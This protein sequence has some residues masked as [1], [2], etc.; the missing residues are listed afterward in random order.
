[1]VIGH[2]IAIVG[3]DHAGTLADLGLLHLAGGARPLFGI[4]DYAHNGVSAL[5]IDRNRGAI[6]LGS[7]ARGISL[8]LRGGFGLR[9][10]QRVIRG[11]IGANA[12]P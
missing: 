3:D 11:G 12:G 8:G 6:V 2:D 4:G 9:L 1:M 10:S 5:F 7:V